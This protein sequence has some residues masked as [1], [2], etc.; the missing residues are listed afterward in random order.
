[1]NASHQSQDDSQL[2][3]RIARQDREALAQ[4]YDRY[5][6]ILYSLLQRAL[7]HRP[8]AGDVLEDVFVE[9]WR[10]A[11][12]Y[13]TALGKPFTWV[14]GVARRKAIERM[15]TLGQ[16]YRFTAEIGPALAASEAAG[17]HAQAG[18]VFSPEQVTLIRIAAE[19]I[20]LEQR[21]AIEMAFLGGLSQNEIADALGQPAGIVRAR[22]RRGM[23]T[24]R[25]RL[26]LIL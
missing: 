18:A 13:D 10:R 11:R 4:L 7:N 23:L 19:E 1:V 6:G 17:A 25:D 5:S 9:I 3:Q 22:I 16:R 8:E 15:R 26:K 20:P 14:L 21:Q 24:L 12:A 2:L